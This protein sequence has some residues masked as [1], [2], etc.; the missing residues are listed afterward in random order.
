MGERYGWNFILGSYHI[1][2]S[3][4][5]VDADI[6]SYLRIGIGEGIDTG[7]HS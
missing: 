7:I 6:G 4:I 3:Y 2:I 1:V 5:Y